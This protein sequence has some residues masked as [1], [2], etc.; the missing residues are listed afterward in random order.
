VTGT[1]AVD[2]DVNAGTYA[3]T[4]S[5]PAGYTG[6]WTCLDSAGKT[7]TITNGSVTLALGANVTCTIN[8][9]DN[10]ATLT[11]DKILVNDNGGT[12]VVTDWTLSATG[13]PDTPA[14]DTSLSGTDTTTGT[15][16][17]LTGSVNAG[18]Y[19]LAEAS[20]LTGYA[21]SAWTCTGGTL[22]DDGVT[23][24]VDLGATV[25]CSITNDDQ[26]STLV[27]D[28][29]LTNDNGG[30]ATSDQFILTATGKTGTPA[31]D[32]TASGGD[33]DPAAGSSLSFTVNAGEYTLSEAQ[34]AGYTA[35]TWTCT[36]ATLTGTTLVIPNGVTVTCSITNDDQTSTLVLDKVLTNDN[37]GT[38]TSDQFILTATGKTGT[39]AADTTASGGDTDPA[40]G[41]S[42]SFTV[43]AGEYTLSEAQLAGYTAGTWTCTGATLTGTTLVIPNGVTVTCTI[44][45]DDQT[46]RRWCWTRS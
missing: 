43:N 46:S 4:E 31:A 39:P 14:A 12:A 26:T 36:G 20:N 28:K 33:T 13:A 29:V 41:S 37:G 8:N 38:A 27:L 30:T 44:T 6:T 21:A 5:G 45:N 1:P 32:T 23:L 11:L 42:L 10:I 17:T 15:G 3:L 34:L 35:G 19:T 24:T 22:A 2:K 7:V 40:A 9:D 16:S 18:T 25:V